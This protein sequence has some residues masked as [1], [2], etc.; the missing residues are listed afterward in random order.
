MFCV[1]QIHLLLLMW[2]TPKCA[3]EN[4]NPEGKL[5]NYLLTNY[6]SK[7][8]PVMDPSQPV[9]LNLSFSLLTFSEILHLN[10]FMDI[11][12]KDEILLCNPDDFLGIDSA[13]RSPKDIWLPDI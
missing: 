9:F 5:I 8:R 2:L 12:W 4:T 3:G 6:S 7:G 11:F 10:F 1:F 13:V